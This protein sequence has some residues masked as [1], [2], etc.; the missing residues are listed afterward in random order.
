VEQAGFAIDA[1]SSD[2][3]QVVR[4][5]GQLLAQNPEPSAFS[6]LRE[7]L[8]RWGSLPDGSLAQNWVLRQLLAALIEMEMPGA[9][10]AAI[11]FLRTNIQGS[12]NSPPVWAI[13]AADSL[14]L[15]ETRRLIFEDVIQRLNQAPQDHLLW[16]SFDRLSTT[17]QPDD[18]TALAEATQ[19]FA[20][21]GI[22]VA[23]RLVEG[24]IQ[25][26]QATDDRPLRQ[27]HAQAHALHTLAKCQPDSFAWEAS[28]LLPY[29]NG[30][31]VLDICEAL[32][33]IGDPRAEEALFH[34]FEQPT[35]QGQSAW[36]E[37]SRIIRALGTCG[38]AGAA[39]TILTYLRSEPTISTN[40][41]EE[42]VCPL[43]RGGMLN[44]D[45]VIEIVRDHSASIQGRITG[46]MALAILDAA[47]NRDL[48]RDIVAR[49]EDE[50]L[51]GYAIRMLGMAQDHTCIVEL[52]SRLRR[53][54]DAFVAAQA[55]WALARM[56]APQAVSDI[57]Q[58]LEEFADTEH[59]HNLVNALEQFRH[60]SSRH[61]LREALQRSRYSHVRAKIIE[62]LGAFLPDLQ[63]KAEIIASLEAW[64]GGRFDVSAQC[65]PI[66]ALARYDP[67][68]LLKYTKTLSDAGR[69][70]RSAREEL[71]LWIPFLAKQQQIE[72]TAL[73]EIIKRLICD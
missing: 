44:R 28:R 66:R 13:W 24:I 55:A 1:L 49:A 9:T 59:A 31:L 29:A 54:R 62:A 26:L 11:E 60:P 21:Q 58:A 61:V 27:E 39:A 36:F 38:R 25:G 45:Q 68:L 18:L 47:G 5:A 15:P 52:Q 43:V 41:P 40:I 69:L 51:R 8:G 53:T 63:A 12:G 23:Q 73:V 6:A 19:Q 22:D 3:W 30:P 64:G 56:N 50:T 2:D 33:V 72:K 35:S 34:K 20:D 7:A 57:E 46:M 16:H 42:A 17:W 70:D 14:G 32:W 37:R 67:D 65:P 48:F 4:A 10:E 71:A